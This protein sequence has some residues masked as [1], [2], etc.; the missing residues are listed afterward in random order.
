MSTVNA[1]YRLCSSYPSGLVVPVAAKDEDIV[2]S[3]RFRSLGRVIAVAWVDPGSRAPL[4]RSAQPSVGMT[5]QRSLADERLIQL[6]LESAG[7]GDALEVGA[8]KRLDMCTW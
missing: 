7:T 2:E 6:L 4:A 3:A 1:G 5:G 8:K